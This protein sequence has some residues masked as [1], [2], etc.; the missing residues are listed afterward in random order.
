MRPASR[1]GAILNLNKGAPTDERSLSWASRSL[2]VLIE[3]YSLL[4]LIEATIFPYFPIPAL[5][6]ITLVRI[7]PCMSNSCTVHGCS[8]WML[9]IDSLS[10]SGSLF[11]RVSLSPESEAIGVLFSSIIRRS[12]MSAFW[13]EDFF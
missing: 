5:I 1:F 11:I 8:Q 3:Y 13:G 7:L 12:C 2:A 6:L 4:L 10:M 9:H